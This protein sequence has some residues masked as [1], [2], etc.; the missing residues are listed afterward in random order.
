MT[1][2]DHA[3]GVV[4]PSDRRWRVFLAGIYISRPIPRASISLVSSRNH[5]CVSVTSSRLASAQILHVSRKTLLCEIVAV[6]SRKRC[7]FLY[8]PSLN[9]LRI[10]YMAGDDN[11]RTDV[12][13]F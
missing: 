12:L 9:F 2:L 4:V 7:F 8:M 3:D 1:H 6:I 5:G 10:C 11:K 13:C